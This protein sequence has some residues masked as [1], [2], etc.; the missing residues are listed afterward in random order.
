LVQLNFSLELN[1]SPEDFGYTLKEKQIVRKKVFKALSIAKENKTDIICFPELSTAK[2][3]IEEA[4]TQFKDMIIVF[5]TYYEKG[6]NVCPI[7]VNNQDYYIR[8]INPSPHFETEVVQGRRMKKGKKIFVFQTKFGKFAVF[9]CMDYKKEVN[10]VLF[11]Q[12]KGISDVDF[13]IVPQF[14]RAIRSFQVHGNWACQENNCP[15]IL[16]VNALKVLDQ[17]IGQT[18]VIGMD[19]NNALKRYEMEGLK[20]K[21]DIRYKLT[22]INDEGMIIVDLDIKKKGAILPASDAKMIFVGHHTLA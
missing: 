6:F 14:N 16:H 18:C 4:K 13:I 12:D 11:S 22:E 17:E 21:D 19:H 1:R 10:R 5:G 9:I 15:Y 7:L 3:W 8:K 2:E 20:P